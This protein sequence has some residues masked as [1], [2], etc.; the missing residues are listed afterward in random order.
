M[1]NR[2][3]IGAAVILTVA[4]AGWSFF[5][6]FFSPTAH[7][8]TKMARLSAAHKYF[9]DG[10]YEQALDEFNELLKADPEN[11]DA[12]GGK[13]QALMQLGSNVEALSLFDE[14]A[15]RN[16]DAGLVY[17]NRGIL[18]DRMGNYEGALAD[19]EKSLDLT[20]EVADGPGLMT[21]F[22]RN[23]AEK[24]PTVADRADYLRAQLARPESQRLLRLPEEDAKQRPYKP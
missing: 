5:D 24:P 13:A 16:P 21:R 23:Q 4:W 10:L 8:S 18:K 17:A 6:N 7:E 9:E 1:S 19:Y 2:S 20:S 22:L 11:I 14:I 15:V 12:L 3:L